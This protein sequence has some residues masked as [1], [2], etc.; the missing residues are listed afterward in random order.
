MRKLGKGQSVVFCVPPEV[1]RSIL[2][3]EALQGAAGSPKVQTAADIG[4]LEVLHWSIGETITDLQKSMP[5]WA[6][7]GK[8]FDRQQTYWNECTTASG[9]EMTNAQANRFLEDE[10]QTLEYRY[11]PHPP[12]PPENGGQSVESTPRLQEIQDR[13]A[14]VGTPQVD[15]ATLQEEQERELSP[16]IEEERQIERPAP[17]E[18]AP[19][20][21]HPHIRDF[22]SSGQLRRDSPAVMPAFTALGKTSAAK[23]LDIHM[24]PQDILATVDFA[25]TVLE[26]S[27]GEFLSDAYQRPVQ[28]ILTSQPRDWSR[29]LIISPYEANE[30][31]PLI[32]KSPH[33]T[34]HTYCARPNQEVQ[35]LDNLDLFPVPSSPAT[36]SEPFPLRHRAQLNLFSGQLYLKSSDEYTELCRT[37]RLSRTVASK[38]VRLDPDNFIRSAKNEAICRAMKTS[39]FTASPVKFLKVFLSHTRRDCRSID[40][41]HLGKIL[42]GVLLQD[43]DFDQ[44]V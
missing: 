33:V 38:D 1:H 40:K 2:E 43:Q 11:R 3:L 24:F 9:I 23:H 20:S 25:T 22:V 19:H 42:D 13:C 44:D 14:E 5:L 39:T 4:V 37:L 10:A 29:V 34:L 41:T 17:Q 35:P 30:L 6:T 7:Q 15:E 21:V 28:W 8:R 27:G 31:L 36:W 26:G 18:P 12:G 16:E 32:R